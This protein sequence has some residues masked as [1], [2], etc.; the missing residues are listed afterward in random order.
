ML[1]KQYPQIGQTADRP[2]HTSASGTET[3]LAPATDTALGNSYA[4]LT[5]NSHTPVP[6]V[7]G[8]HLCS[9]HTE[10]GK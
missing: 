7:A 8:P 9:T 10:D 4:A 5:P 2:P 3:P 6:P 1:V